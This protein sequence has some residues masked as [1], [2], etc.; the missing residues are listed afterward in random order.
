VISVS[1]NRQ[2]RQASIYVFAIMMV[3][4]YAGNAVLDTFGISKRY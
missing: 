2:S 4:W 3:A 1:G